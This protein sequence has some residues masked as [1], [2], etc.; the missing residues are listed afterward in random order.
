ML[1]GH[2]VR[3]AVGVA[4]AQLQNVETESRMGAAEAKR[5][6]ALGVLTELVSLVAIISA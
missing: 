1:V 3:S 5:W 4:V 6:I 2:V